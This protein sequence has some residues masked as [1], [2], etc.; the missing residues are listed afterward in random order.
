METRQMIRIVE[1]STTASAQE[2]E[3][4]L[5][6]PYREG[7]YYVSQLATDTPGILRWMYKRRVKGE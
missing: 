2:V 3:D 1:V 4:A 6:A 7:F 5:N